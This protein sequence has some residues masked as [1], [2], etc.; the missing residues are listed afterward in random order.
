MDVLTILQA[1]APD[2]AT[3]ARIDTFIALAQDRLSASAWGSLYPQG[4][5]YLAAHM[6]TKANESAGGGAS[7]LS[8]GPVINRSAGDLSVGYGAPVGSY[9]SGDG[10]LAETSYGREFIALR[11][12]LA[13]GAPELI[14]VYP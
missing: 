12:I 1:I 5:A 9:G 7:G 11:A 14:Q 3:D 8:G 6:L 13:A 4:V 2:L 10:S